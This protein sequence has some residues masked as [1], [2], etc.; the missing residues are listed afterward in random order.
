MLQ[1][2]QINDNVLLDGETYELSY[3][4]LNTIIEGM[5]K[6]KTLPDKVCY[7]VSGDCTWGGGK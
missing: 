6:A 7:E 4:I 1:V 3:A 5:A 2:L